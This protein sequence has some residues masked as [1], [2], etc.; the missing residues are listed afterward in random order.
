[1]K[2]RTLPRCI[3]VPDRRRCHRPA[4][5][6]R[7][8][9]LYL[10]TKHSLWT[11]LLIEDHLS[12]TTRRMLAYARWDTAHDGQRLIDTMYGRGAVA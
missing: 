5:R 12:P 2:A 9:D 4:A 8:G 3:A 1:M 11:M 7:N 10:C 6:R